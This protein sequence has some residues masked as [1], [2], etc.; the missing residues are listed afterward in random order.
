[1]VYTNGSLVGSKGKRNFF[2]STYNWDDD[3]D[4][5]LTKRA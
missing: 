1:M 2:P 4:K 5:P 3:Q